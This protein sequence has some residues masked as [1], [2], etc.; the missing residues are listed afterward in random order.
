MISY[1]VSTKQFQHENMKKIHLLF[2]FLCF[3]SISIIEGTRFIL[4]LRFLTFFLYCIPF[5]LF[6][7]DTKG[8]YKLPKSFIILVG[9]Y[10][11]SSLISV[12]YSKEIGTSLELFFRDLSLFLILVY[13]HSHSADI[14]KYLPKTIIWLSLLF[15]CVSA[16]LFIL[17]GGRS[18]IEQQR[19][20]LLFNPA[21]RHNT[22]GDFLTLGIIIST[23]FLVVKK[24]HWYITPLVLFFLGMLFSFSRTAYIVLL[25]ILIPL[26]GMY[27]K[28]LHSI[29]RIISLSLF[30]NILL[31]ILLFL[32]FTSN[33]NSTILNG[34]QHNFQNNLP[35]YIR[36]LLTSHLPFWTAGIKGFLL[37]PFTGIGAG[38][39]E[40]LSYR[41][42]DSVFLSSFTSFNF[43]IDLL[44]E[45]G[46]V[47]TLSFILI[48]F[49]VLLTAKRNTPFFLLF[50]ALTIG[51]MGYSTYKYVQIFLLFFVVMGLLIPTGKH[52]IIIDR[53]H[54]LALSLMAVIF[55]HVFFLHSI[56]IQQNKRELAHVVYPFDRENMRA[57]INNKKTEGYVRQYEHFY[58]ANAVDLEFVGDAYQKMGRK[59]SMN[60]IHAYE[61][62]FI[63]GKYVYGGSLT[64]R[65]AK[66][67]TLKQQLQGEK[68]AKRYVNSFLTSYKK[69]LANDYQE[70]Q[71]HMYDTLK[72]VYFPE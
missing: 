47:P 6:L 65:M 14:Q 68:E 11:F 7:L 20:N 64:D 18:F 71:Q 37:A 60:A 10:L 4:D 57:L 50:L 3:I 23:Y 59:Y 27:K 26:F 32:S 30:F 41:F 19:L 72:S 61:Q 49:S 48:I 1:I 31:L 55:L 15:I 56:L 21:Y 40:Y 58:G 51:F 38:T 44:A 66:L 12:F 63:W 8:Q 34:G 16:L 62:S 53:K 5:F 9:I 42:A 67:Y 36:P 45:Q 52:D 24:N 29:P 17:P 54:Y 39:F 22:I 43:F 13:V 25:I 33:I 35:I 70:T 69:I 28:N 2:F 46:F